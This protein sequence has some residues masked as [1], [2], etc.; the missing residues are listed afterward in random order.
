MVVDTSLA[1]VLG[2]GGII[3]STIEHLMATFFALGIDNALVEIDSHEMP[4]LDGSAKT[5]IDMFEEAGITELD[6]NKIFFE[7]KKKAK[8]KERDRSVEIR[9][10]A[11]FKITSTTI[12][13]HPLI[14]KQKVEFNIT[15]EVFKKEI[16]PARTF[17]FFKDLTFYKQCGLAQ[18]ATTDT[19]I[20]LTDDGIIENKPL[21][22]KDEFARHKLLDCIGDMSLLGMPI[23]GHIIA[24]KSGH[25]FNHKLLKKI[26]EDKSI[27]QTTNL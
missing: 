22:F 21:R 25:A 8:I 6:V 26:F 19:G 18:G 9:P 14:K 7:I 3:V 10:Y 15:P 27:W 4:I 24:Y 20:A 12:Y 1:T 16:A 5:Y 17:G 11:G 2:Q 23:L 13:S